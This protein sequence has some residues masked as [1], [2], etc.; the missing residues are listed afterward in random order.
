MAQINQKFIKQV[1]QVV[2]NQPI[3]PEYNPVEWNGKRFNCY[4][5]AMRI[6]MNLSG[7]RICPGFISRGA[8]NN[9]EATEESVLK[10]FM[11]DCECLGLKVLPT[12]ISAIIR[13]N[14]YKIAIYV[15]EGDDFHFVRRDR[16]GKWSEKDGWGNGINLLKKKE[17]IKE[18]DGYKFIGIFRVSR[19]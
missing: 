9:Y 7:Y 13:K 15:K 3:P 10:L 19:K 12:T 17:I 6:C 18:H 4:A 8:D 14:E 1:K 5:Y 16:N 2:S 11:E